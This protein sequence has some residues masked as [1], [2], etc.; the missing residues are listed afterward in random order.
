MWQTG[1][2]KSGAAPR[3]VVVGSGLAG[4]MCARDLARGGWDVAVVTPGRAGRDGATARVH[5]LAPWIL[6]SAPWV[7]GDSPDRFLADLKERGGGLEREGLAEVF[8]E[9]AHQV[10]IDLCEELELDILEPSPVAFRG[11]AFPRGRR[12]VPR[13]RRPLLAPLLEECVACGA[14]LVERTVAVGLAVDSERVAGVAVRSRDGGATRVLESDVV[15]LACGGMGAVFP[16]TTSPRWCRGSGVALASAAGAVLHA[17]HLVQVL[18]VTSTPP[19]FFPTTAALLAGDIW[20]GESKLA[21]SG[22]LEDATRAI[23][24]A[25]RSGAEVTLAPG[26]AN[27]SLLPARVRASLALRREGRV[28][29]V[30]AAHHGVGGVAIDTWGRTSLPGLYACGEAAGGVQGARRTM[31]TGLLEATIFGRRSARAAAR[32][33]AKMPAPTWSGQILTP[34]W[35]HDAGTLESR[36]DELMRPLSVLRPPSEVLA[37]LDVLESW[38]CGDGEGPSEAAYLGGLRRLAAVELLRSSLGATAAMASG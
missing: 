12:C 17:P 32:D 18:P 38:P 24:S 14:R 7:R 4:L 26:S 31:G 19:L 30:L 3:A 13:Q 33:I 16:V 8:A 2:V 34:P 25:L 6:L 1:G 21:V 10:A 11:D 27:G 20:V 22:G 35:A 5:A 36:M 23:A 15:V 28:E 29:L 37:V 9:E